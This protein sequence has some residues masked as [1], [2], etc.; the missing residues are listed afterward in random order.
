MSLNHRYLLIVDGSSLLATSYYATLPKAARKEKDET[1]KEELLQKMLP[2]N[3]QGIPVNALRQFFHTLFTILYFQRPSHLAI[4]W[5]ISRHTFRKELWPAYKANRSATPP[6]LRIQFEEAYRLCDAL[7]FAQVR[8]QQYEADDFAGSI[9]RSME[10]FMSVRI[11]TRDKD[12]FQLISPKTRI[13]YGMADSQKVRELRHKYE[14]NP[15]LPSKVI[16]IDT[17]VL[18]KEFGCTPGAVIMLK[19]LFGDAS[20]NI[21]GVSGM[22]ENRSLN[23][24][25]H[26]ASPAL[27]Y[28]DIDH[29]SSPARRRALLRKWRAWGIYRS[30][31]RALTRPASEER[32]SARDMASLCYTL[33]EIKTD[34]ALENHLGAPFSPELFRFH[35][36]DLKMLD[37]L[38][39]EA[40]E[41]SSLRK[42]FASSARR[43]EKKKQQAQ[44]VRTKP[45]RTTGN[46]KSAR[47]AQN[48][49]STRAD[50]PLSKTRNKKAG[51]IPGAE[52]SVLPASLTK[53]AAPVKAVDTR[54]ADQPQSQN[55]RRRR[56][57]SSSA[58]AGAAPA[59]SAAGRKQNL[60]R[61]KLE[62][63]GHN[64]SKQ[65]KSAAA[66][67]VLKQA[68]PAR[69]KR[70]P[71]GHRRHSSSTAAQSA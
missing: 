47:P 2:K 59:Q 5:D 11:L 32:L 49:R 70:R 4:C 17:D 45:A 51:S 24:A 26:Y 27:L 43:K 15:H 37:Y 34:I 71:S 50:K 54:K 56:N 18:K 40:I 13:W 46:Q 64:A 67:Q 14:M 57:H 31:L 58:K 68:E 38:A 16:E 65:T 28:S 36:V 69:K 6:S 20:D 44:S 19:S 25:L 10:S 1:R 33:G 52:K 8:D 22:G 55:R 48:A 42:K 39:G 12:Y 7:G 41:L 62:A 66:N 23:L 35:P 53:D 63:K 9:A 29:A 60:S 3:S 21:P 30:P 61:G